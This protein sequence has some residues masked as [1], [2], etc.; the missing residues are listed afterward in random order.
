MKYGTRIE[1]LVTKVAE[2]NITSE[3]TKKAFNLQSEKVRNHIL[4][5]DSPVRTPRKP[6]VTK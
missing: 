2:G 4:M 6:R 5:K 1:Q 3:V